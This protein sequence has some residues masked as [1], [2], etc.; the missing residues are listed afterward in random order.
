MYSSC[1][2]RAG[3]RRRHGAPRCRCRACTTADVE[4][5]ELVDE[6]TRRRSQSHHRVGVGPGT[7]TL[8]RQRSPAKGRWS[9]STSAGRRAVALGSPPGGAPS[10]NR[11]PA[12][13]SGISGSHRAGGCM[14][15]ARDGPCAPPTSFQRP[16]MPSIQ[17]L[18]NLVSPIREMAWQGPTPVCAVL[19]QSA[20][21][22]NTNDQI[23]QSG[24]VRF[25]LV[26]DATGRNV[27]YVGITFGG[28]T[29]CKRIRRHCSTGI[30][31]PTDLVWTSTPQT[32]QP[33]LAHA[34]EILLQLHYSR[35]TD[36]LQV[37]NPRTLT[38]DEAD[39]GEDAT[40]SL[41][42]LVHRQLATKPHAH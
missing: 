22:R 25:Y 23:F 17:D 5:D 41:G 21:V 11:E 9:G 15:T 20:R 26:T 37:Y 19:T 3:N 8:I 35:P 42:R 33:R 29:V 32:L 13:G 28:G 4:L 36:P 1:S 10:R 38:F 24:R 12:C 39:E 27:R 7:A 31:A 16:P 14:A 34:T 2:C 30:V 6:T 40:T 18:R